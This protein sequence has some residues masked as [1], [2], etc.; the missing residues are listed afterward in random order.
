[1]ANYNAEVQDIVIRYKGGDTAA[2]NELPPYI[3]GMIYSILQPFKRYDD[4][5]DMRQIAWQTI[6]RCLK[7]YDINRGVLFTSF[8][9]TAIKR[10]IWLYRKRTDKHKTNYDDN[11]ICTF[12]VVPIDSKV[13]LNINGVTVVKS[14]IDTLIDDNVIDLACDKLAV[15]G[16][17]EE[18][19][20]TISNPKAK[21]IVTDYIN[22]DRQK[23][24]AHR[25]DVS[26]AYV[27]TVISRFIKNCKYLINK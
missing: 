27:C 18:V 17:V 15:G 13:K 24:I 21:R 9:Y 20:H 10:D 25:Y 19:L 12:E 22:G 11:N 1:M 7:K 14:A 4:V 23:D 3:D 6:M 5:E 8:A 26:A 16:V 2:V